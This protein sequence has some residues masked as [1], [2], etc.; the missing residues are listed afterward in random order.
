MK[1]DNDLSSAYAQM[2]FQKAS[3][4]SVE[5][6]K[7]HGKPCLTELADA[8]LNVFRQ[9]SDPGL[10]PGVSGSD[11]LRERVHYMAL[12][13]PGQIS[14]NGSCRL[15]QTA[16]GWLAVNLARDEDWQLLPAWLAVDTGE[17]LDDWVALGNI[18]KQRSAA[19]LLE[20]GRL[21]GLPVAIPGC[22][23]ASDW[24]ATQMAGL[25]ATESR[26]APLVIDL[27][28]L[29]AG[30]LACHLLANAGATVVKVESI[31]RPDTT[32]HSTA[33]FHHL[34]NG[35]K[36]SVVVDF[37][38]PDQVRKLQQLI[39]RADIVLESSRP[40]ALRQLGIHAEQLVAEVPG[41]NWVSITGYGRT[42]PES[43]WVAFGDDAAIAGGAFLGT[44]AD[45]RFIGD[46]LADPLTGIHAAIAAWRGWQSGA[47][48]LLDISLA[49]VSAF[50]VQFAETE[51]IDL[52]ARQCP[53]RSAGRA[54]EFGADTA[55][56]LDRV[57][58]DVN[59]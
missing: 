33:G 36:S 48:S 30:P 43:N 12:Q 47:G 22:C 25:T 10:L 49:G 9:I 32:R 35:A 55:T 34:L 21:L 50:V 24:C 28:S 1:T 41:L 31:Q 40:R 59:S 17:R 11:L 52:Q 19:E 44:A 38:Q 13:Q 23:S 20:R 7:A 2:L 45:P 37:T 53:R 58:T 5:G 56:V 14:A 26:A 27:S 54:I 18:L 16:S 39:R 46:A 29:W 8:A 3:S 51:Q 4:A 6:L 15:M 57:A 42:E